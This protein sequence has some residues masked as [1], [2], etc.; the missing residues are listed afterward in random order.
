LPVSV[1]SGPFNLGDVPSGG[2]TSPSARGHLARL[3]AVLGVL[4][5]LVFLQGSPCSDHLAAFAASHC[6]ATEF[7]GMVIPEGSGTDHPVPDQVGS[8]VPAPVSVPDAPAGVLELCL[9]LLVAVL[10]MMAGLSSPG[11]IRTALAPSW[12]PGHLMPPR[13]STPG[14]AMLCVLRT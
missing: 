5:G 14:L 3:V 6:P 13:R 8:A 11:S 10:L 1:T 9:S 7:T 2:S 12:L 4:V